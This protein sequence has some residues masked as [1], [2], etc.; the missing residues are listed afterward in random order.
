MQMSWT[1][2]SPDAGEHEHCVAIMNYCREHI[3]HPSLQS[4]QTLMQK[5]DP[6]GLVADPVGVVADPFVA[7]VAD[8]L[9]VAPEN[10]H[11]VAQG[12]QG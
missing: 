6:V 7:V 4:V 1:Q 12:P 2:K 5:H 8:G 11:Q 10:A 9:L 3:R